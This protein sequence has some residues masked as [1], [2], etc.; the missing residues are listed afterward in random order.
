VSGWHRADRFEQT[1][2]G[3]LP[4]SPNMRTPTEA[5]LYPG[6]G[7]LEATNLSV[8]RGTDRPF[9]Q[10]GA[11]WLD[12]P[13]L[14]AALNAAGLPGIRFAPT[15]LTPTSSTYAGERCPAV[16]F[17]LSDPSSF[18]PVRTG[19]T[20]ALALRKRHPTQWR[21]QGLDVLLGN[22]AV[23]AAILRGDAA[24]RIEASWQPELAAFGLR[25][26]RYLLY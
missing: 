8:G 18:R 20:I 16:S 23:L 26:A 2:L 4:T 3:W 25:R 14:S 9:E 5:L 6:I 13:G 22:A 17:E 24:E 12:A 11:P 21:A 10:I 1:G 15:E 19:I 7:L